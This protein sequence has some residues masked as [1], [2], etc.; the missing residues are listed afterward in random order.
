MNLLS[1]SVGTLCLSIYVTEWPRDRAH[2]VLNRD[3]RS[4][5]I[6]Y[7]EHI[8]KS[9]IAAWWVV[10]EG[11]GTRDAILPALQ[12]KILPRPPNTIDHGVMEIEGWICW[13]VEPAVE[14]VHALY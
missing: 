5:Y 1:S 9:S 2:R 3:V 7:A 12:V 13:R 6:P 10:Q 8:V 4:A 14:S 11:H